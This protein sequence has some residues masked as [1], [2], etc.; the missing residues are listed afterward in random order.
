MNTIEKFFQREEIDIAELEK[1]KNRKEG[2][3]KVNQ[4]PGRKKNSSSKVI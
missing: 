4:T 1:E 2:L 3:L